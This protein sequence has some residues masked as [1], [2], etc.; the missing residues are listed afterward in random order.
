M[1]IR[2]QMESIYRELPLDRIPWNLEEPPE[3]LVDLI[4]N[5]KIAPCDA[6]D[7]GDG[8]GNMPFGLLLRGFG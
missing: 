7:I 3:L 2:E 5:R 8:C 4:Q 1:G 6:V